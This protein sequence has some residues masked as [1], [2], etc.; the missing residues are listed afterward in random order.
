MLQESIK[1]GR[2]TSL[3]FEV[4]A[5][6]N[7]R[8]FLALFLTGKKEITLRTDCEAPIKFA[9]MKKESKLL[10]NRWLK[11]NEYIIGKGIKFNFEH[12]KGKTN[13]IPDLLS[14]FNSF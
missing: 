7:S 13:A 10:S 11:L 2:L 8:K 6:I 5:V 4:L 3:D 12:I 1:K 9:D 14:R